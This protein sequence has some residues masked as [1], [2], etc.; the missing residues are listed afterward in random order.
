MSNYQS[1]GVI[2]AGLDETYA[3]NMDACE[4]EAARVT[5]FGIFVDGSG[6]MLHWEDIMR[7]CLQHVK[8]AILGSKQADEI[9]VGITRFASQVVPGGYQPVG[10]MSTDYYASGRTLLYD[11]I[12]DGTPRLLN[13][14]NEQRANGT[15][16]QGIIVIMSDGED[17]GSH[18]QLRD[19]R[20]AIK[21][22]LDAEV[23]VAY[24]AFGDGAHG[25]AEK[26]GVPQGNIKNVDATES[27]LRSI[28][29]L[30]SRS[31]ISASKAAAAGNTA[32]GG[33]WNV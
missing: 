31:A 8:N 33:F 1:N 24:I 15:S 22:L 12:V 13:Y 19:A 4:I 18:N 14:M 29:D 21:Q 11:A 9:Q 25:I 10:K 28:F 26:L 7:D 32:G 27:E 23:T 6:S 30:M 16:T 3:E 17:V 2:V 5:N 20:E